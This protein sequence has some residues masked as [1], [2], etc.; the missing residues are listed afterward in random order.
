MNVLKLTI[1]LLFEFFWFILKIHIY[2]EEKG[3]FTRTYS[4]FPKKGYLLNLSIEL[5]H[6]TV[7]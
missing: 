1:E 4:V 2:F 7:G 3:D 6:S 5:V